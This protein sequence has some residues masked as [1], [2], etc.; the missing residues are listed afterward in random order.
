DTAHVEKS[1]AHN[2]RWLAWLTE[3]IGKLGLTVT[4]SAAN[5]V[6]IHFPESK[7]RTAKE[8]DAFLTKR[9]LILRQVGVY[10]LPNALRMS[11]GTEEANR[12]VVQALKEFLGK[13]A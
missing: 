12:L 8:A 10:K 13:A 7:G 5:F 3:E 4:P 1:R 6:L 11:V 9:G 2:T